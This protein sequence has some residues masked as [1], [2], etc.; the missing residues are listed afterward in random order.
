[1]S[2][3][4]FGKVSFSDIQDI[5]SWMQSKHLL[6]GSKDCTTCNIAMNFSRR[7]DVSDGYRFVTVH[8]FNEINQ[9]ISNRQYQIHF[10]RWC[11]QCKKC[12]SVREGSFFHKSKLTLQKWLIL[13][14]WWVR[15]YPVTD[16]AEEAKVEPN[17]AVAVY[18]WL[19]VVCST[20][21][22]QTRIQLGGNGVTVQI[23]ESFSN[24]SP[25]YVEIIDS[26]LCTIEFKWFNF[27]VF[28]ITEGEQLQM[29]CG[30]L[31]W[32]IPKTHTYLWHLGTWR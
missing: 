27:L 19:C 11:P 14:Y 30:S 5:I 10:N 4:D 20:K 12:V 6:A 24:I 2:L 21:L 25:K 29:K 28:S 3:L 31:V 15:Q 9:W 1:M 18:Q 13:L 17:T 23:D 7:S 16:A 22:I 8:S 26:L 32:L